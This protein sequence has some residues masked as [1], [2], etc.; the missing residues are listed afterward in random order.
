MRDHQG[1]VTSKKA[2]KPGQPAIF[3]KLCMGQ[4]SFRGVGVRKKCSLTGSAI[5][6]ARQ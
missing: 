1:K 5:R 2:E 3:G 4:D 6:E